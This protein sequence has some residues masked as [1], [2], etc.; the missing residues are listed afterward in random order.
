MT[1]KKYIV[2]G[3]DPC[4]IPAFVGGLW[5]YLGI[6]ETM[7]LGNFPEGLTF[8]HIPTGREMVIVGEERQAQTLE[9]QCGECGKSIHW[10]EDT[11]KECEQ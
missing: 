6:H 10:R 1:G 2:T 5:G 8:L 4:E 3:G 11:C 7:K 9:W